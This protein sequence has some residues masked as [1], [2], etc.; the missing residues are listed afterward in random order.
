MAESMGPQSFA[1][2]NPEYWRRQQQQQPGGGQWWGQ[3]GT[4]GVEGP[5]A[6]P[7]QF[8]GQMGPQA[9]PGQFQG[10]MGPQFQPGQFQGQMGP[11]QPGFGMPQPG[12][13][14][15]QEKSVLSE[16]LNILKE[17]RAAMATGAVDPLVVQRL[18]AAHAYLSGFLEARGQQELGAYIQTIPP[19]STRDSRL[20]DQRF[21]EMLDGLENVL[22]EGA[23]T[24]FGWSDIGKVFQKV[25]HAAPTI[26]KAGQEVVKAVR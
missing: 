12:G 18:T 14:G 1:P 22:S 15:P 4:R 9:Q 25:V 3:A 24:R 7:G 17:G 21:D 13:L 20:G 23:E 16:V 11:Q 5:Q 10:Q 2:P 6:Q 26:W 19:L 8:Q